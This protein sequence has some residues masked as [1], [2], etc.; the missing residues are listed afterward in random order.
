MLDFNRTPLPLSPVLLYRIPMPRRP[1]SSTAN[2]ADWSPKQTYAALQKQLEALDNFRG[3]LYKGVEHDEKGWM[4]LTRNILVHGF[5]DQGNNVHQFDDAAWAGSHVTSS[6]TNFMVHNQNNFEAR[7]GAFTAMLKSTL[8]ELELMGAL[9]GQKDEGV[10]SESEEMQTQ[11]RDIFL[12]HGHDEGTKETVA[13]LLGKLG[14][15][16]I[17]L[18]E[19]PNKGRTVIEK[20]EAHSD[21]GFAVAL[22]TP[23]DLGGPKS[24]PD[25]LNS[26][27]RQNVILEMG[28]FIG[29]LG[30]ARVCALYIEGV[31]IPSDIHG[32]LYVPLD[33]TGAW[34]WKLANE[35]KAAGIDVD[36]NKVQ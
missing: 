36:M 15:N 24:S 33:S 23:D 5:G 22:L 3:R 29:K 20:F 6:R 28:Y 4:N 2:P 26:R 19:Q 16:P 18:H 10:A 27:A 30:R 21:V 25:K 34:R 1:P 7:L 31:E 32:V 11:S 9:D 17:I 8:S 14:L 35:I 13:R 12:I